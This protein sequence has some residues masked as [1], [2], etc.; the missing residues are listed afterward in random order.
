MSVGAVK[1]RPLLAALVLSVLLIAGLAFTTNSLDITRFSWD[2]RYY[3]QMA[4][5][6]F[7]PPLASPFAYRYATPLLV[8]AL[9]RGLGISMIAGFRVL[10]YA[11]AILQLVGVFLFTR[12]FTRS[13]K[14]ALVAL[15][16]TA[17]SLFNVKFLLF[18]VYRPDHLAY[19][20][21]LLL[22]YFAFE[23]SFWPLLIL[24]LLAVQVREFTVIPLLAYL[25][26][27]ADT[28]RDLIAVHP[29][30]TRSHQILIS[31]IGLAVALGL[32]RLL[33]P[34]AEDFQ[35]VSL[36]R[37]GLLRLAL[38]PFIPSRDA[39][40][41]YSVLAYLLPSLMIAGLA[42]AASAIGAIS[43]P[44]RRYLGAYGLMVLVFSF[45]GGTDFYRFTSYLF[46]PQGLFVALVAKQA[47]W[48]PVAMTLGGVFVFNRIWL[49]FPMS[50][51][52]SYLDFYGGSGTRFGW[53]NV[54]RILECTAF[55]AAAVVTRRLSRPV[56]TQSSPAAP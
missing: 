14:G 13:A 35:F 52:G 6:P 48:L 1:A 47:K 3:I 43:V 28:S 40:F 39:N 45:L 7:V 49:P 25:F 31:A 26:G 2:F 20:L 44:I 15:V 8:Y 42:E 11:G 23:R 37:D 36:T 24:T 29:R 46:L 51:L 41:I 16:V 54:M 18:D 30:L 19:A 17:F 32:P 21:I 55:I 9:V 50:D 34:V 53:A 38:A 56:G 27:L 10:A 12:W 4:E 22:T 33:I 5:K